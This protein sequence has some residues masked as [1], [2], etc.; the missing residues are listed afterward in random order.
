MTHLTQI[1]WQE[2]EEFLRTANN[3]TYNISELKL[4]R[5]H[6]AHACNWIRRA[7]DLLQSLNKRTDY[8]NV[9]EEL[10]DVLEAGGSLR[11]QGKL[12]FL[13]KYC[14]FYTGP[15][16]RMLCPLHQLLN[17]SQASF[18]LQLCN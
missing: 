5:E 1:I 9:V 18:N 16:W 2:L 3:L 13:S 7:N 15:F 4:L 17:K 6:H 8:D 14:T 10:S 12:I 11:V